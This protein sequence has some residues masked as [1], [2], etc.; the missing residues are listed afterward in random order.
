L[1]AAVVSVSVVHHYKR[2]SPCLQER[3]Q[4]LLKIDRCPRF[5]SLKP[6]NERLRARSVV[7]AKFR[8]SWHAGALVPRP[9]G[10]CRGV[11]LAI[12]SLGGG[13][14]GCENCH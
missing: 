11:D 3:Y 8:C 1:P 10:N 9:V 4:P 12:H 2:I 13:G 7:V 6:L 5:C 14:G